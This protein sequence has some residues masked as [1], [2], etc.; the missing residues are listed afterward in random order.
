MDSEKEQLRRYYQD[1]HLA[2][3][4]SRIT[5]QPTTAGTFSGSPQKV[6]FTARC[7]KRPMNSKDEMEEYYRLPL[8]DFDTR[9]PIQWWTGRRSLFPNLSCLARDILAIPGRLNLLELLHIPDIPILLQVRLLLSSEFFRTAVV[10]FPFG[11]LVS[12]LTLLEH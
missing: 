4:A 10:L 3:Q 7:K 11:D 6:K 12:S 1:N 5:P 2:S 8:E 9:D